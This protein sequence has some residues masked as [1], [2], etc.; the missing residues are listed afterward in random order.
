[1]GIVTHS[2]SNKMRMWMNLA[3]GFIGVFQNAKIAHIAFAPIISEVTAF[4][5]TITILKFYKLFL[6]VHR[7]IAEKVII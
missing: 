4:K 1:M 6:N 5:F 2:R 7:V 3:P